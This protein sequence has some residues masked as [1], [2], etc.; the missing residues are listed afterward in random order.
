MVFLKKGQGTLLIQTFLQSDG[1][2]SIRMI[3]NGMGLKPDQLTDL[4]KKIHE[5]DNETNVN[6]TSIGLVN[7]RK[8]LKLAFGEHAHLF[9]SSVSK[10]YTMVE[11]IIPGP[12]A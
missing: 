9:I 8:R 4:I 7:I 5:T 11:F 10:H 2:L 12:D 3:D 1:R 6:D